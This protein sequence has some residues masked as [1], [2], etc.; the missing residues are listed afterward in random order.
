MDVY[1][2]R[3]DFPVYTGENNDPV[4]FDNAC[5]T[6]RP[7]QVIDALNEY[8]LKYP[9]C[10]GRSVHRF[11]T[12]VSIKIDEAREKIARFINSS[13]PMEIIFTKN[14]TE[15]LNL[16]AK[17]LDL[18]KGDVVL[19]TDIEHNSN[20]IPWMQVAKFRGIKRKFIETSNDGIFDLEKFKT[21]MSKDIKVVSFA[22]ANNVVGT[23]IP[24]KDVTEIAHDYGAIVV[25]DGAQAAP[26]M[27]V[28]VKELDADFYAFSMHKMLGPSG[29][30][31]LY[32]KE[33]LL[34]KLDPLIT[35]GG[36]VSVASLDD[37]EFLPLPD[38]FESGLLNYSGIIGSSAAIDY[39]NE[40][41]LES[42]SKH[43]CR[44]NGEVTAGLRDNRAIEILGPLDH[45]LRGNIFSFNIKGLGSHDVAMM[46]DQMKRIMIRSGMHCAHPFFLKRGCNGCARASFY[47]YNTVEECQ[48]FVQAVQEIVQ[49]FS[50]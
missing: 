16:V 49:I 42:I 14:C 35:G 41:G 3:K 29:V 30:G 10:A 24:A 21:V 12:E 4:Y 37:V 19:T 45:K 15:A 9:A 11:A 18:K 17:G 50:S 1:K 8:Y 22:H 46:L 23:S 40:I 20:H 38:R 7:R 36:A 2:I 5:Q 39:I 47:I 13:S 48:T 44:L 34:K 31:V 25:L 6:L 32:G 43:V 26:H 33:G 28:D 27:R